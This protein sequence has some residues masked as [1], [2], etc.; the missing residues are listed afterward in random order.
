MKIYDI[1]LYNG[2]YEMLEFRLKELGPYVDVFVIAEAS[3]TF[4][5]QQKEL[6]FPS[7]MFKYK[8]YNIKYVRIEE[9][10]EEEFKTAWDRE[11]YTRIFLGNYV[12]N[13]VEEEDL[14]MLS[15]VDEIPNFRDNIFISAIQ[16]LE[17]GS[18]GLAMKFFYYNLNWI[19][20]KLW[21][22]TVVFRKSLLSKTNLEMIRSTRGMQK[23][24]QN[25]YHLSYFFSPE[26]IVEKLNAFSHQEY[27]NDQYKN[28]EEIKYKIDNGIDLFSRGNEKWIRYTDEDLPAQYDLMPEFMKRN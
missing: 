28:L 13:L 19:N 16:N 18:F 11:H 2:E 6:K 24:I 22:G 25:G 12:K 3:F 4:S 17:E 8:D 23:M 21:P 9:T 20:Q 26:G 5:G 7:D 15:D 27:N 10:N 14:L 1:F